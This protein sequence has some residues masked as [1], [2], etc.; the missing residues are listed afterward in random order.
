MIAYLQNFLSDYKPIIDIRLSGDEGFNSDGSGGIS[1]RGLVD[2][3]STD[4]VI[5]PQL[6]SQLTLSPHE[7]RT[8]WSIGTTAQEMP[9]YKTAIGFDLAKPKGGLFRYTANNLNTL[10][11]DIPPSYDFIIPMN[12]F[13]TLELEFKLNQLFEIR[14]MT[15]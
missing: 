2:T 3:G 9:C 10:I 1:L 4:V 5:P 15:I 6:A 14:L 11:R 8:T 7:M 13:E 12:A